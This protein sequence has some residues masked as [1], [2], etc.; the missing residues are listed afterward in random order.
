MYKRL[1]SMRLL[2]LVLS[3][4]ML[5]GTLA[6]QQLTDQIVTAYLSLS[7]NEENTPYAPEGISI[8]SGSLTSPGANE[9]LVVFEDASQSRASNG[10][11]VWVFS[12]TS[13]KWEGCKIAEGHT[14]ISAKL[15]SGFIKDRQLIYVNSSCDGQGYLNYWHTLVEIREL[16]NQKAPA[17]VPPAF[18]VLYMAEGKDSRGSQFPE[19]FSI[20]DISFFLTMDNLGMMID[21]K[22]QG[23][24]EEPDSVTREAYAYQNGGLVRFAT[25]Q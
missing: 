5:T 23:K 19:G 22:I 18:N 4:I 2:L 15:I 25:E 8:Y 24:G 9:A 16:P 6:A 1:I 3:M 10:A 7:V 21:N 12:C 11:E 14:I 20:H 17:L 13:G